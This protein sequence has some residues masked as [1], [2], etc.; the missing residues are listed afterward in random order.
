MKLI[1]EGVGKVTAIEEKN[2]NMG[3]VTL[4]H[5]FGGE[6]IQKTI[7]NRSLNPE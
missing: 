7:Y 2:I 6:E 1:K 4:E 5:F 3:S